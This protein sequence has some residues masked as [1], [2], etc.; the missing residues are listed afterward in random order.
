MSKI[1]IEFNIPEEQEQANITLGASGMH[2]VIWNFKQELRNKIK[3]GNYS[4]KEYE[5]LEKLS[6]EF[7]QELTNHNVTSLFE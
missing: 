4:D 6:E 7:Y 3:Y 5:L 2:S 1:T